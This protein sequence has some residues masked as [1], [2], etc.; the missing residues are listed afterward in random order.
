MTKS[1][2]AVEEVFF[3]ALQCGSKAERDSHLQAA[4]GNDPELRARVERLLAAYPEAGSFLETPAAAGYSLRGHGPQ[5]VPC[6]DPILDNPAADRVLPAGTGAGATL[7]R[8]KLLEKLGEGGCGVVYVAEQTEPVRRRVALKVIKLGMDTKQVVARFEAER[9]AL[10]M[11]D[12]PNI[13][14]VFDAETTE[15]GRPYFVMELVRGIPMTDYCDQASLSTKER[16]GLFVKVCQAIQHA[17]QKGIIHRDIKPGNILVTLHDGVPVPKVIDF[18][19]AKAIEGRLIDSTVYTQLHQFIGTPA[20]M[21]PEQAEMSGLDIDTRSD[22]YSLGVLLYELLT[23]R[24]PF[25]ASELLAS[26]IDVMRKAIREKEPVKPSSRLATMRGEELTSTARR[27]SVETS[28]LLHQ[29]QGDLDWIA[30]KCLEKD[31]TRRYETAN[32][33]AAD[34]QRHLSNELVVARPPTM[35]YRL[36]K[37]FRRNK[38]AFTAS[39]AI[40]ASLVIGISVS[41]WQAVRA[42]QAEREQGGLRAAAEAARAD[43]A[44]QRQAAEAAHASETKLRKLAQ[45]QAYA[46]DMK[47]AQAALEQN[48]RQQAVT[49]LER[50]WPQRA[51]SGQ[52]APRGSTAAGEPDLRGIEWRYL[53]QAAKGDEIYTWKL[54]SLAP[55]ALFSPD[56]RQIATACFDGILRI[57]DVD[58]RKPVAQFDRGVSDEFVRVSFCYAPDGATLA[59]AAR[60]GIVLL[61]CATWRV[62]R[63]LRLP[64]TE[65]GA[66][67]DVSLAYSPD[68]RWLA[69]GLST[70]L[71]RIW[72]TETWESFTLPAGERVHFAFSPDSKSVAVCRS[73]GII[74]I[75]DLAARAKAAAFS[76][77]PSAVAG[78]NDRYCYLTRF[79]P[80]GDRLVAADELG[81]LAL[82]DVRSRK[83]IW[84]QRAHRS[85]ISGLAFSHDGKRFA[86]GGFDQLVHV[87]DTATQEKVMTLQGHLNEVWSVGFSPDDRYLLTSSKDGTVMLWDA[88]SKPQPNHWMLDKDEWAAGFTPDGRGLIT[89]SGD[90]ATVRHWSGAQVVKSLP[91][92]TEYSLRAASPQGVPCGFRRSGTVFCQESQSLYALGPGREIRIHDANTLKVKRTFQLS[93]LC[94]VLYQVSPNERWVAG[95]GATTHDL[96]VWDAASGKSVAH[97]QEHDGGSASFDLAVFSPDSRILALATTEREVKLWDTETRQFLRTFGPHPWRVYA[98]SFSRDG[99]YLASSS[100]EGDVRIWAVAAGMETAAPL[101]G[102][103]S[104]VSGHSFSPDGA[105][106][107]TGG[108]DYT[109]RFW[110]VIT[111]REMLVFKN[112]DNQRARLP[113]LSPTGQ[114]VVWQDTVHEPRVRVEAIPTMAEIEKARLA[115]RT[116]R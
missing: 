94:S 63:T 113:F 109:V 75:W 7:G 30:M 18:G 40:A 28:K 29:L 84:T 14:K 48:S 110:H 77:R 72:R 104:G 96:Y 2:P 60:D 54:P 3:Q 111:G 106:L 97:I 86:S 9:Q 25:D 22:I 59:S 76:L 16:L 92:A 11:M 12:H 33:L 46:A 68:G 38:L 35:S 47:A 85:L 99:Q 41:V 64:E 56:G 98:I 49:L 82:W 80:D 42:T 58:S 26:G 27:R 74:E 101:Y 1:P 103:G 24:T 73:G 62:K 93:D 19:I 55:G 10:A 37:L 51:P 50:Y 53:W 114:L 95:R 65:L 57:W 13:A 90:G 21:S 87:W 6:G 69:A 31:R 32:G 71:S 61:D 17:H 107:V 78:D 79:S 43:E 105:T 100:W 67:G 83:M 20:Y 44:A 66:M 102:H 34:V 23:G 91:C 115:Q 5:G 8:Y 45:M 52:G 112:A 81:N 39:V 89:I 70:R 15:S 108:D 116:A 4:C 88:L 36:Q